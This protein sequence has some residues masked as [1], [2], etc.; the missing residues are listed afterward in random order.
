M[1]ERWWKPPVGGFRMLSP[2]YLAMALKFR[3]VATD[4]RFHY[5]AIGPFAARDIGKIA[6]LNGRIWKWGY[7]TKGADCPPWR[8]PATGGLRIM[9]AGR[10]LTWKRV[11]TLIKAISALQG[12]G[13]RVE[14]TI[15]GNGPDQERLERLAASSLDPGSYS[16]FGS[17]TPTKI[18]ERM[19]EHHVYVL[20][21]TAYE[22]WG[23]VVNEA[24]DC[25]LAVI[26][27]SGAGA[28][29]AMIRDRKNGLIF[30]PGDWRSLAAHIRRLE[31]DELFR[32]SLAQNARRTIV[33]LWSPTVAAQRLAEFGN[34]LTYGR[35]LPFYGEGPLASANDWLIGS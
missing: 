1:S 31:K 27:S 25:G 28:A 2:R 16:F 3:R 30:E 9:W 15:I 21:S 6:D 12:S 17:M 29:A 33:G 24:M 22:G 34:A 13:I 5:L 26:A 32:T 10:M 7:F 35:D 14:L 4:P 8:S 18:L 11:D 19:K 23:A 20:P